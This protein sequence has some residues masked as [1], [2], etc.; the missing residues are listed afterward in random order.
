MSHHLVGAAEIAEMLGVSRQRVAQLISSHEDFPRPEVELTG[1]RV[2][3]RTAVEAWINAH[4]ERGPDDEDDN[5]EAIRGSREGFAAMT[6][7][8][9]RTIILS[10][11]QARLF[12]H[13]YIGTEH[14]LLGLLA[15]EDG[16][17][18]RALDSLDVT[19]DAVRAHLAE[20][21]GYGKELPQGPI[22][23]TPRAKKVLELSLR[24]AR[25]AAEA[26]VDTEH[27]LLA[28]VRES[29][30]VAW[31]ILDKLGLKKKEVREVALESSRSW[32]RPKRRSKRVEEL[33]SCSFCSKT[34][35]Q[36]KKLIAGPGVYICNECIDLCND[37][38]VEEGVDTPQSDAMH[39]LQLRV[40]DLERIVEELRDKS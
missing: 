3:S 6:G 5:L 16:A 20:M 30:G 10:Q 28:L 32:V 21:I 36:V 14:L 37:I 7:L 8:A 22:P 34:Q 19:I 18:W 26:N 2:W 39:A 17:A 40:D 35:K 12:K 4:P 29:D 9:R 23:F 25:A 13:N 24:E 27:I 15:A 1:G 31:Q 11:E 33:M 38:I